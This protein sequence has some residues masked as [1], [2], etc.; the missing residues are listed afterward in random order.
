MKNCL[1]AMLLMA[2]LLPVGLFA[3]TDTVN[4]P[5]FYDPAASGGGEGSLNNAI[6]TAINAGTISSKVFKLKQYGLYVLSATIRVPAG[7]KLTL[8]APDPGVTQQT[9]PPM[10]C[11]TVSSGVNTTFNFDCF[12][13]VYMKNIWIL[14][15]TQNTADIG[16]QVGSAL[17]IDED[18]TDHLNV[19]TF[20]NCIFDYAPISNGGGAITVSASHARL[21]LTNCYFRNC[22]DTHFRYYSRAVS[23]PFGTS[24]WHNDVVSFENCT[25]ANIGYV[26]MQEAAEYGD[27]V[28]FNH[29]TFLNT[30][31]YTLES[32]WWNWCSVTN[33]LYDNAYMFG[34]FRHGDG[35]TPYGGALN[36]DS[37]STFGFSV[38]F[39]EDTR[40]ILF[41]YNSYWTE[42][43]LKNYMAP[44]NA[45]TN[46]TG[47]NEFSNRIF[48]LDPDSIPRPQPMMSNKT[49][50]FFQNKTVWPYVTLGWVDTTSAP[51]FLIPPTNL[52]GVKTFLYKKWYDN[53]DT[54]WA[55]DP[56]SDINQSWPINENMSYTN[57]TLKTAAMGSFPLGDLY[58]WW[59][60]QYPAWKAQ[61]AAEHANITYMLTHTVGVEQQQPNVPGEYTLDQN[62]PNPFNPSTQ[63]NYTV[64]QRGYLTLKVFNVLGQQVS[65]LFDG[66]RQAGSYVATF[67]GSKLASGV[68]FYRLQSN[69]VSITKKLVLMK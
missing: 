21:N 69:N 29:C 54:T 2:L 20:E 11:W 61:S 3:Q 25:F 50:S 24:G 5:D 36:I 39:T 40:H 22:I 38:P 51:G 12:G 44:Y 49:L 14:Y 46:P 56:H 45:T 35:A 1:H 23:F 13:D 16:T 15:A 8:V 7:K 66:V 48:L 64:P 34:Y 62:Y 67:D 31:M 28:K 37:I 55:F 63:I 27:T 18:S 33:C 26:Y 43:W 30:V 57:N 19:G 9:S 52:V 10:I 68:Y 60:G 41:A 4:V 59:P 6:T 65:T 53:S 47:G 17:E 32:G 58:H 42:Q